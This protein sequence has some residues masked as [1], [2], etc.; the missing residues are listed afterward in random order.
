M[1]PAIRVDSSR[2]T[3]ISGTVGVGK[4]LKIHVRQTE[5]PNLADSREELRPFIS[6][7]M[8]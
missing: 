6:R 2:W 5:K 4:A 8:V 3:K 1:D 7:F